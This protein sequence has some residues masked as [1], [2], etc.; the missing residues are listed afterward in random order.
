MIKKLFYG[1]LLLLFY[2]LS[3]AAIIDFEDTPPTGW[4]QHSIHSND[5]NFNKVGGWMG[6][7]NYSSLLPV[8]GTTNGT[9]DLEMGYG[10]FYMDHNSGTPFDFNSLDA[11]LSWYNYDLEDILTIRGYQAG[12]NIIS[13]DLTLNHSYQNFILDGFNNLDYV[14]FTGSAIN[15]GYI[16]IDHLNVS[17]VPEPMMLP[18]MSI[19]LAGLFLVRRRRTCT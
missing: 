11:G 7:N 16:A 3:Q 18:L 9:Q 15:S 1:A 2:P 19:G 17:T 6:V 14:L 4:W 10:L 5:Y 8:S 12:G 13:I